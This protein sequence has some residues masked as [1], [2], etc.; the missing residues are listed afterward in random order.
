[1]PAAY[2][3]VEESFELARRFATKEGVEEE[4][5]EAEAFVEVEEEEDLTFIP[6]RQFAAKRGLYTA[7]QVARI[8]ALGVE[9]DRFLS[10]GL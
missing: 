4:E 9:K 5:V 3:D 1:M 7:K 8:H 2:F 6:P 10:R